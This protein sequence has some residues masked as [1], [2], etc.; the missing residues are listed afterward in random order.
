M[1]Y[2]ERNFM[3][4][5]DTLDSSNIMVSYSCT[6]V[7]LAFQKHLKA[8]TKLT[9]MAHQS[10]QPTHCKETASKFRGFLN[11]SIDCLHV[12]QFC[13]TDSGEKCLLS[14]EAEADIEGPEQSLLCAM[15]GRKALPCRL[16]ARN[17]IFL[18]DEYKSF[19]FCPTALETSCTSWLFPKQ[20]RLKG[21]TQV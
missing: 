20:S 12:K 6:Q 4:S 19:H 1:G 2:C 16:T 9:P 15:L 7:I 21:M 10:A 18:F 11:F 3:P 14:N 5:T 17:A 13:L 8:D